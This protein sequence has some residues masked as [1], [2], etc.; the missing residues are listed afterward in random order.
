VVEAALERLEKVLG[1]DEVEIGHD[2]TTTT[3][4][5]EPSRKGKPYAWS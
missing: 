2:L 4:V 1:G 5:V 3:V